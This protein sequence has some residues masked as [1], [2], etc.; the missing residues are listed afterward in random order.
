MRLKPFMA[1][2]TLEYTRKRQEQL[3]ALAEAT[4]KSEVFIENHSFDGFDAAWITPKQCTHDAVVLYL[5]GGGYAAGDLEYSKG[6]GSLLASKCSVKV[7]TVAYR[8]A[9]EAKF[10]AAL[11]DAVHAY[12]FLMRSGYST[13]Q[14]ILCGESSGGG[15]AYALCLRLRQLN[16]R[17]PA[18]II[19]ISPWTD[20]TL[21]GQSYE[22]NRDADPSMSRERLDFYADCYCDDRTD[23]LVSPLFAELG[24]LPPSLI[25]V[26][27]DEIMLEDS[28]QLHEKL[29]LAGCSSELVVSPEM[30]HG[31]VLY[32]LKQNQSDFEKINEFLTAQIAK[33]KNLMWLR[34]DNAAKI[35]PAARSK[36]WSNVF[37][38]SATLTEPVDKEILSSALALTLRRFPSIAV[39]I[40]RG[41]FWYY[42]EQIPNP[43]ELYE[44]RSYPLT[45]MTFRQIRRCAF[46]VIAYENRIAV[47]YFHAVTD[48]TGGMI[49]LKSLVAEYLT[50]KYSVTIPAENGVL[51][52]LSPPKPEELEDSFLKHCGDVSMS[53]SESTAYKIT[54]TPTDSERLRLTTLMVDVNQL[55]AMAK[56]RSVSITAF[57]CAVMMRAI[58]DIQLAE[59]RSKRRMKPV[60]VLIP[61][62]LRPMFD[63]CTMRNFAQYITPSVDPRMGDYSF[64][65]LCKIAYHSMGKDITKKNMEARITTNVRSEQSF[66]V[67]IMPLFIKDLT[68]KTVFNLVGER[69]SCLS[70]SNIGNVAIPD[71]MS[72]YV[73]RFDFILGVQAHAPYNCG[74]L[75]YNGTAYMN[76]I[77]N[78]SEPKL[79]YA[80]YKVLRDLGLHVRVES[81][82][83]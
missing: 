39:R 21:S 1:D 30:W 6:F 69:K 41:V 9:P 5:H 2:K 70:L 16:I 81:N 17:M 57:L 14:I 33:S 73:T 46:R 51:D 15:L 26:G 83:L 37:R 63:S 8:L 56:A 71:E 59:G 44:E 62:N 32:C 31:Y 80:F 76:F 36:N 38:L 72:K 10:P 42:F 40:R 4:Y 75:S 43:P 20:L 19:A 67:K 22:Y 54:G 27:G 55:H 64:D 48:G 47:E 78:I 74:V 77:R 7:F 11:D 58:L 18:G 25:F 12:S 60:K 24:G 35:Y 23:P 49:F 3:G 50:Q 82:Q 65:E 79:E 13:K 34:L 45:R 52:R 29:L 66:I 53:R 28:K 61:V 68:L